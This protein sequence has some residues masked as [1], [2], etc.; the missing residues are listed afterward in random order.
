LQK[1]DEI[2]LRRSQVELEAAIAAIDHVEQSAK[3]SSLPINIA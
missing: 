1:F 2:P 3:R